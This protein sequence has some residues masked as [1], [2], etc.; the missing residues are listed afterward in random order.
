MMA[1]DTYHQSIFLFNMIFYQLYQQYIG[2]L[3]EVIEE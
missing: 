1:G 3:M 2:D